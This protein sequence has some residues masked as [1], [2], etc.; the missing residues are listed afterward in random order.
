[1]N[2]RVDRILLDSVQLRGVF[3]DPQEFAAKLN[4]KGRK[5]YWG[6]N[7]PPTLHGNSNPGIDQGLVILPCFAIML[8]LRLLNY[9]RF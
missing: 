2:G 3:T 1:M 8:L 6:F 7:P 5:I 9:C 4:W